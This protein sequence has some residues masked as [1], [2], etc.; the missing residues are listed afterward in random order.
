MPATA[1]K[2]SAREK[3]RFS[4]YLSIV[5]NCRSLQRGA[6]DVGARTTIINLAKITHFAEDTPLAAPIKNI[7]WTCNV[8]WNKE[9]RRL[10]HHWLIRSFRTML[11]DRVHRWNIPRIASPLCSATC[12]LTFEVC[13]PTTNKR[14]KTSI[15]CREN[16][17]Q[18]L[19]L[20]H[21]HS[22]LSA[23]SVIFSQTTI[24]RHR[25]AS[26]SISSNRRP[27]AVL[28]QSQRWLG[29]KRTDVYA[30]RSNRKGTEGKQRI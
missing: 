2:T 23:V 18:T 16:C 4:I 6:S 28:Q 12:K 14:P 17:R 19:K 22:L 20:E 27:V 10:I 13:Q 9:R 8:E 1:E 5:Y 26:S 3:E 11:T 21:I 29:D 7:D 24:V 15:K 25:I 30:I